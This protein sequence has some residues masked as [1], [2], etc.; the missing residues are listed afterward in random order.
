M[1]LHE[2]QAKQLLGR[3]GVAV[4]AGSAD[5]NVDEAVAAAEELGEGL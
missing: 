5:T 1:K 4:A 3:F 2:Y